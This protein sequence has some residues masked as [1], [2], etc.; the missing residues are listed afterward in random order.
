MHFEMGWRKKSE[1]IL[2]IKKSECILLKLTHVLKGLD[3]GTSIK[4][5]QKENYLLIANNQM[6][7]DKHLMKMSVTLHC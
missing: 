1:S 4:T 7:R 2:Q 5:Y 3:S 6:T